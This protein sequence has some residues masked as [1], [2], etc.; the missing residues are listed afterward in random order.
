MA[1]RKMMGESS[2][3]IYAAVQQR[4]FRSADGE[5]L[6]HHMREYQL[7]KNPEMT[8]VKLTLKT[9]PVCPT[10]QALPYSLFCHTIPNY[11]ACL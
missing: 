1:L 4:T 7:M 11:T 6:S 9:V 5:E 3:K 8:A 10:D 2:G